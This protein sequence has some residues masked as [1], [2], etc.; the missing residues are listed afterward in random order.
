MRP[1]LDKFTE[2]MTKAGGNVSA[3]AKAFGVQR[4]A[5]YEWM[6]SPEYRQVLDD[7]RGSF[8]DEVLTTSRIVA[9]GIPDI[10]NG[11]QTGWITPPDSGMLR[12]LLGTLGRNEG[13]AERLEVDTTVST[14]DYHPR[15]PQDAK[16][17]LEFLQMKY[18]E[19]TS[20]CIRRIEE[21][22]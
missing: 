12:Y 18:P 5:V 1:P 2:A 22:C 21:M 10:Q 17:Y 11:K 7:S 19:R 13:F 9:R 8:F 4:C 15:D 20:E 16:D 3:V 14:K 6:K